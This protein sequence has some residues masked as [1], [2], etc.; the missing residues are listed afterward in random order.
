MVDNILITNFLNCLLNSSKDR[1]INSSKGRSINSSK[2]RSINSSAWGGLLKVMG[3]VIKCVH[4]KLA[5]LCFEAG[6]EVEE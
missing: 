3:S 5:T 4:R 2:D 6:E 1:S